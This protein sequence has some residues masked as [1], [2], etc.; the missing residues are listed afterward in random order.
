MEETHTKDAKGT[1]GDRIYWFVVLGVGL[2]LGFLVEGFFLPQSKI[3]ARNA[4][5]S[6][7]GG[8]I[9]NSKIE[10]ASS[11]PTPLPSLVPFYELPT[12]APEPT[13]TPA[14]VPIPAFTPDPELLAWSNAMLSQRPWLEA[15]SSDPNLPPGS[16]PA[17]TF[18]VSRV[19]PI[20]T[21][22]GDTWRITFDLN[23]RSLITDH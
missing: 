20:V 19:E 15:R 21:R 13:A 18:I 7:A 16:A 12:P 2:A 9:R 22:D 6:D 3:P 23:H 5:H 1:K 8:E 10:M 14:P 4:S 11:T 17:T